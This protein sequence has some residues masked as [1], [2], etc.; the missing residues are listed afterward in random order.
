MSTAVSLPEIKQGGHWC[1]PARRAQNTVS[2]RVLTWTRTTSM[3]GP[4]GKISQLLLFDA[5][6]AKQ[7]PQLLPTPS[8]CE[9]S[10]GES[11]NNLNNEVRATNPHT[12][13]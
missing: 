9:S 6:P 12:S 2:T 10:L 11:Y 3:D 4:F 13:K 1:C 5:T 8:A 7:C